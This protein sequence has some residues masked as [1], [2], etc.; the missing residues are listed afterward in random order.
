MNILHLED[1]PHDAEL[2][3]AWIRE[4]WP[5]CRIDLV[6]SRRAFVAQ[7][8]RPH[9][10]VLS[11]FTLNN[12]NGLD[13]LH[14]TREREPDMPFI[15]LSGTIGEDRALEALRAGATDYLIK[16]R[17]KRLVSA[18]QRA[19]REA[20]MHRERRAA[21]EQLLRV[22]RLENIGMLAAGIAHDFNN[23]LAPMLMGISL[24]RGRTADE[25]DQKIFS[26][27]ESSAERGAG[28]IRQILG[29]AHGVTGE[30]QLL[31]PK[32]LLR[33]LLDLITQTFPKSIR[34]VEEIETE[35]W[36]IK[37]NPTQLHQVLLNLCVNA[38]DAM[39][40]RRNAHAAGGQLPAGRSRRGGDSGRKGGQFPAFT[41]GGFG[42]RHRGGNL[43]TRLGAVFHDQGS[44]AGHGFGPVH[45]PEHC[46]KPSRFAFLSTQV[47]KGTRFEVFLPAEPPEEIAPKLAGAWAAPRGSGELILVADDDANVRDIT[48]ATLSSYG[49]RVLAAADG[50][51]AVAL[52]APRSL[53]VRAVV[54]DLEMPNLDGFA[55]I[56]V[57]TS[58]N[59]AIRVL[60]MSASSG[61]DDPR[62]TADVAVPFL[63]KPFSAEKLLTAVHELLHSSAVTST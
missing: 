13:A 31:Q 37:A 7:L 5:Q 16:D 44:G 45:G 59:P 50:A 20:R 63:A 15:F 41:G 52:L 29:F 55:L 30:R 58:L 62:R 36:P 2:A 17:P 43:G 53:E 11:D 10:V 14:L 24:L 22:Q 48:A 54:T 32:Y 35:L 42:H 33:E 49:Y 56:K 8:A 46:R 28:L 21:S 18:I 3:H 47:G 39:P 25:G 38:R 34:L 57:V 61:A 9:D 12:F 19:L 23:V 60:L 6:D 51:E 4:E 40:A 27:M 26:S 1:N